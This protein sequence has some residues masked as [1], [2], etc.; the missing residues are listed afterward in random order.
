MTWTCD[1]DS[2]RPI[3]PRWSLGHIEGTSGLIIYCCRIIIDASIEH[4]HVAQGLV[5]S[6]A[7][8]AESRKNWECSDVKIHH[9]VTAILKGA[10]CTH[11]SDM[12]WR[13]EFSLRPLYAELSLSMLSMLLWHKWHEHVTWTATG[14]FRRG[15]VSVT[16]KEPVD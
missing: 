9:E 1:M 10:W 2:H 15:E 13:R 3:P 5:T 14:R 7:F 4:G 12:F 8:T 11:T 6:G 16:L